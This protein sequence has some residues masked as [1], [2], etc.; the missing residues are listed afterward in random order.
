[1]LLHRAGLCLR[2]MPVTMQPRAG[3]RSSITF[4]RSGYYMIKVILAILVGLLR[5][6]PLV[7]GV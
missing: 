4:L 3:G 2:E 1:V 6:A 7:E 5:P